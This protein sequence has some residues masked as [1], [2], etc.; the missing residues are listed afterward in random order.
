MGWIIIGSFKCYRVRESSLMALVFPS[1]PLSFSV[2]IFP[3]LLGSL[4]PHGG[5]SSYHL[6]LL[7]IPSAIAKSREE[8]ECFSH[9]PWK[10]PHPPS[11]GQILIPKSGISGRFKC[12][13][14]PWAESE[15]GFHPMEAGYIQLKEIEVDI[16][17]WWS[18]IKMSTKHSFKM[19]PIDH[20]TCNVM[21]YL[22]AW[23][24][25]IHPYPSVLLHS[26]HTPCFP[27]T[28]K[29][30][31]HVNTKRFG[32]SGLCASLDRFQG[33]NEI[34]TYSSSWRNSLDLHY[35]RSHQTFVTLEHLKCG[36]SWLEIYF[37][38]FIQ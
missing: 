29:E 11:W 27:C 9:K 4:F 36:Y 19:N 25:L 12:A 22:T 23:K 28:H 38:D 26:P 2:L 8:P 1:L 14:I 7:L 33:N 24:W 3:I 6:L 17:V 35:Y 34:H 31:H 13:R 5:S 18:K 32:H 30:T 10:M 15:R 37:E 21:P 16:G 20:H